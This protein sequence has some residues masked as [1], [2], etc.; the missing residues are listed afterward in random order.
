MS[1]SRKRKETEGCAAAL[2]KAGVRFAFSTQGLTGDRGPDKFREGVRKV[3]AAGLPADV[4]L[5][6]LT[7]HAAGILDVA[8]QLGKVKVGMAAHLLV[9]DGDFQAEKTKYKWAFAD[10]TRFDLDES[11]HRRGGSAGRGESALRTAILWESEEGSGEKCDGVEGID[12]H[13]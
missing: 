4:A 13:F 12:V 7:R 1:R 5:A 8:P 10:G 6:S 11:P 3:I 9:C 2:H